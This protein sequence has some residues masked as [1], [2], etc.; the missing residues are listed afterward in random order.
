MHSASGY[1]QP[2]DAVR[3]AGSHPRLSLVS[4][5]LPTSELMKTPA[6]SLL[7]TARSL[8]PLCAADVNSK[9]RRCLDKEHID[10]E[11]GR[12]KKKKKKKG[13]VR[14]YIRKGPS[15]WTR[16]FLYFL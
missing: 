6:K 12:Q 15:K 3:D 1:T 11:H 16:E 5:F 9:N 13:A 4:L 10:T 14:N 8:Q 7:H 2:A